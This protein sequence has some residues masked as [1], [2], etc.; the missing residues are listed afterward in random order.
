ML[1]GKS[2]FLGDANVLNLDCGD[3]SVTMLKPLNCTL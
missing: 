3:N 2:F 1:V